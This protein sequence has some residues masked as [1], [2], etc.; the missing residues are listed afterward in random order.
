[1][2][3]VLWWG[4]DVVR[5]VQQARSGFL[6]Y[7]F[8]AI[9]MTGG[10][11]FYMLTL[12]FLFWCVNKSMAAR[13][14]FLF[15][16]SGWVNSQMKTLLNQPRPYH[17]DPAV[18][19]AHTGGPGLPSGHAQ[20][21]LVLWG[22]L[23][24]WMRN[25]RF[26]MGAAA[27]IL[28]IA[29]SRIYLGVHFPTDIFGGWILALALM[30]PFHFLAEK[31]EERLGALSL[32]WQMI[33][34]FAIPLLFALVAP[35]KWSL[36]PMALLAG[37]GLAYPLERRYIAMPDAEGARQRVVRYLLGIAVFLLMNGLP[38]LIAPAET[39][40]GYLPYLFVKYACMG[41]W[42]GLGAP[43]LFGKMENKPLPA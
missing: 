7:F 27:I 36:R 5:F 26:T 15:L 40:A 19:I 30:I 21:S 42:T 23:S 24:L 34:G 14:Y 1:M 41:I 16:F 6:D 17:L 28:L 31:A 13:F 4:V 32:P 10:D 22:Y 20:G 3:S 8:I 2:E 35:S 9:T 11:F 25:P 12:P 39:S 38:S 29:L 18:K 43:W 37:F 33:L